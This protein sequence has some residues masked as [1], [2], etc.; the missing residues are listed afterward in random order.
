MVDRRR[1]GYCFEHNTLFATVLEE[2]GFGVTRCLGRVRMSNH[3]DPRPATHMTLLV[4]GEVVDVGFGSANPLGPVPLGGEATYGPYTWRTTRARSP[5]GEEVWMMS[6][7]DMALYSFTEAPQ[8]P[9]DYVT[10]NHFAATHR[11]SL[12]TQVELTER[13]PDGAVHVR[14]IDAPDYGTTLGDRFGI[15]LDDDDVAQRQTFLAR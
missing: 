15:D 1:G 6:L 11:L 4:D 10:P 14:T 8:H 2:L 7:L 13:L 12:F 3:V 9:V 5:E